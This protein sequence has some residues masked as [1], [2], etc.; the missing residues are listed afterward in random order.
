MPTSQTAVYVLPSANGQI[1]DLAHLPA[2]WL[3]CPLGRRSEQVH[4]PLSF[5]NTRPPVNALSA[6]SLIDSLESKVKQVLEK[7][8][9]QYFRELVPD[10][11]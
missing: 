3:F 10:K 8:R 6:T 1:L 11:K 4:L 5:R 2:S 7:V 9:Y